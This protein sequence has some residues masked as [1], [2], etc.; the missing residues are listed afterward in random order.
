MNHAVKMKLVPANVI[1]PGPAGPQQQPPP[2]PPPQPRIYPPTP[3][4]VTKLHELDEKM[5]DVLHDPIGNIEEKIRAYQ[6]IL[7]RYQTYREQYNMEP[8]PQ[9][10]STSSSSSSS[11]SSP[12]AVVIPDMTTHVVQSLPDSHQPKARELMEHLKNDP[13]LSYNKEGRLV[14]RGSE[15]PESNILTLVHDVVRHTNRA[16]P[17]GWNVFAQG[18]KESS[19]PLKLVGNKTRYLTTPPPPDQRPREKEQF[20]T[21]SKRKRQPREEEEAWEAWPRRK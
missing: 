4:V 3:P 13:V 1:P 12:S 6:Q 8:T 14:Y 10:A 17:S 16:A 2:P 21:R 15:V 19:I 11:S 9:K 5:T 7:Q 18:L 20:K